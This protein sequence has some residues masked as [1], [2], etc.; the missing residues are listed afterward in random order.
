MRIR[1][2]AHLF[3]LSTLVSLSLV[4]AFAGCAESNNESGGSSAGGS[5]AAGGGTNTGTVGGATGVGGSTATGPGVWSIIN[6]DLNAATSEYEATT[7]VQ[8]FAKDATP[9]AES[10]ATTKTAGSCRV[11]EPISPFCD[12]K[13]ASSQSCSLPCAATETCKPT[14]TS[15]SCV[16][17]PTAVGMGTLKFKGLTLAA[18]GT[19]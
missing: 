15:G 8:G 7:A 9:L 12:P 4:F 11:L 3:A 16:A 19:E 13:C 1:P 5:A 10:F 17:K 18:G 14:D 6:V 2:S